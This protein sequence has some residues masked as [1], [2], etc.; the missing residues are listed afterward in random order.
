VLPGETSC[1]GTSPRAVCVCSELAETWPSVASLGAEHA[2]SSLL[3]G[4]AGWSRQCDAVCL[5][6]QGAA[7]PF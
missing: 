2:V 6:N 5:L 7:K 4:R 3:G 1:H